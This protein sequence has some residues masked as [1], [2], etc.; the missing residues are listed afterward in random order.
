MG[1]QNFGPSIIYPLD[2][3]LPAPIHLMLRTKRM[4][5][6]LLSPSPPNPPPPHTTAKKTL[7]PAAHYSHPP[8]PPPPP[9]PATLSNSLHTFRSVGWRRRRRIYSFMQASSLLSLLSLSLSLSLPSS[10]FPQ[11]TCLFGSL[12]PFSSA[13]PSFSNRFCHRCHAFIALFY[14]ALIAAAR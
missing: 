13:P 4:L 2:Y 14:G 5:L 1:A 11:M 7:R 12:Y 10:L 8:P 3:S 9:P 6:F